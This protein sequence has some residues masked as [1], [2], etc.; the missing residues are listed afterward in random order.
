[1]GITTSPTL[2]DQLRDTDDQA[3]WQRFFDLYSPLIIGFSRRRGCSLHQ[4][5]DVLQESM[6]CLMKAL[7]V[8]QYDQARGRFRAFLFRIVDARIKDA[9]RRNRRYCLTADEPRPA[10]WG[11]APAADPEQN[12]NT[13]PEL[14]DRMW[15]YNLLVNALDKVRRR[16]NTRT[17]RS[18]EMY[19]LQEKSA[20]EVSARLGIA[21][22][23]VHQHR[24]RIIRMLR[25]ELRK[26]KTQV[27]EP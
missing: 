19:V 11:D 18:F 4:A 12:A 23:T 16:V 13:A 5:H 2:L 14:W 21:Q 1:M 3:A 22:N 8:F 9:Y 7:P 17:F 27:G 25:G 10:G 20:A 26:L 24:N 6:V 15:D